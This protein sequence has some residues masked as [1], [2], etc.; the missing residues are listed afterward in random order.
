[1]AP[2]LIFGDVKL[3]VLFIV[4]HSNPKGFWQFTKSRNS[5][6][7]KIPNLSKITGN[8]LKAKSMMEKSI[9]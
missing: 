5:I 8:E 1:M 7:I 4:D 6:K 2:I 3:V 9:F